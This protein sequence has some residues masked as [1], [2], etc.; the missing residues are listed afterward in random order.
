MFLA[1]PV[2]NLR[3]WR[4][5]QVI[6]LRYGFDFLIEQEELAEVRALLMKRFKL[7]GSEYLSLSLPERVRLML[8]ELGPTYIK[9]GQILSSRSD[10]LS[11][12]WRNELARLQDEVPSF[13]FDV[14]RTIIQEDFGRPIEDLFF[15]FDENT[16]AGASIGQVHRA[17]LMNMEKV[18]VKV[19]RPDVIPQ[20]QSDLEMIHELARLVEN[21]TTW[22]KRY[23]V[24]S[25]IEEFTRTLMREMDYRNEATNAIRLGKILSGMQGVHVPHIYWHLTSE[26][27]LTMEY[28]DGIKVNNLEALNEIGADRIQLADSLVQSLFK[29]LLVNGFFHADPHPGNLLVDLKDHSLVFIDLGMMGSLLPEQRRILG[30]IVHS[31]LRRDSE[32]VTRLVM[33]IGTPFE[34]V[35]EHLLMRE[36]DF[37]INRYLDVALEDVS[38][39]ALIGEVLS[40]VFKSGL[41]LPSE[42]S[43]ALKTIMQGEDVA[44]TLDQKI[45]IVDIAR[46]AA[47]QL[48][49]DFLNPKKFVDQVNDV[50]RELLRLRKIIPRA[51]ESILHQLE[52]GTFTVAIDIPDFEN[53]INSLIIIATRLT[54]GWIL[55]G[56]LIGSAL[57]M[58]TSPGGKGIIP[59]LGMI[60]FVAALI[61]GAILVW[62]V[63]HDILITN[64]RKKRKK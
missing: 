59:I 16:L 25:I 23:G 30:D 40:I 19:R 37:I 33:S 17:V 28:I 63:V 32:D 61:F 12:E 51:L 48:L 4:D 49:I 18:V 58:S 2:R 3:R 44:R 35:N 8:E 34:K 24:V 21:T 57:A 29:Q 1:R 54:A 45:V 47:Q 64:R 43:L 53:I 13:P 6:L 62:S 39:A 41:R 60:G 52:S 42:F 31:L 7:R 46:T 11:P 10:L 15:S 20:V 14:V 55:V 9:M 56:M 50:L 38:V 27:V 22:G 36:I 26:R 5:I